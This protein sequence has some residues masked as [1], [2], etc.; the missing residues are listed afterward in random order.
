MQRT[1]KLQDI[2][3]EEAR[4]DYRQTIFH[5]AQAKHATL[6]EQ[7][8]TLYGLRVFKREMLL[9]KIAAIEFV[10]SIFSLSATIS[11]D[12]INLAT[13][14]DITAELCQQL[15]QPAVSSAHY[16]ASETVFILELARDYLMLDICRK[17]KRQFLDE[18]ARLNKKN[19]AQSVIDAYEHDAI[20]L[21]QILTGTSAEEHET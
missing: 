21:C 17:V 7:V 15:N 3:S 12:K 5:R 1:I 8:D 10:R 11:L 13:A 14:L 9:K 19:S 16:E 4:E 20:H 2:S 6:A 18:H